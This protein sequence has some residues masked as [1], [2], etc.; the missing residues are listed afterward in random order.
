MDKVT[1]LSGRITDT[2]S[3]STDRA[4]LA[5]GHR[6]AVRGLAHRVAALPFKHGAR[7]AAGTMT[8]FSSFHCSRYNATIRRLTGAMVVE[9]FLTVRE[10]LGPLV[11]PSIKRSAPA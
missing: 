7:Q 10:R 9:A 3:R 2:P 11:A 8:L 1:A 5:I 6:S 4:S